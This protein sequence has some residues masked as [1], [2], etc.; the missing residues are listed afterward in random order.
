MMCFNGAISIAEP[1]F[2]QRKLVAEN[3]N[4]TGRRVNRG[5]K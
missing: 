1:K 2:V 4:F 3:M 5:A